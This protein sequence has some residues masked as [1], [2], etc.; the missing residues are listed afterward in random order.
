MERIEN[1]K[2]NSKQ[3]E[4]ILDRIRISALLFITKDGKIDCQE[5]E[6]FLTWLNGYAQYCIPEM[7]EKWKD[8]TR[9]ILFG[10]IVPKP[11]HLDDAQVKEYISKN[12]YA[13]IDNLYNFMNA[14]E[15][16][17]T[18]NET[19]SWE[20][21]GKILD[22]QGH[23]G[24]TFSG[25]MNVMIEY[26]PIGVEFANIYDEDRI[27]RDDNFKKVYDKTDNYLE[28]RKELNKRLVVAL[29]RKNSKNDQI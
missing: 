7:K 27:N 17:Q 3:I 6:N 28:K 18:Y 1:N 24:W 23:S 25:L 26:S 5:A 15:I 8:S 16:M 19:K 29:A 14:G 2:Y 11:G 21:V 20:E 9:Q 4:E 13:I 12:N 10:A 22:K